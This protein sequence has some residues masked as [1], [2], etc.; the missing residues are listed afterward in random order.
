[1]FDGL[2]TLEEVRAWIQVPV[3]ALSDEQ[4]QQVID[5]ELA[6]QMS[7]IVVP[8]TPEPPDPPVPYPPEL[9]QA[10]FRRVA[11]QVALR[12]LPLGIISDVESAP[13]QAAAWDS[14][15]ARLEQPW[16]RMVLG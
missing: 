2:P 1:M 15:V 13:I 16:Q 10:L 4:L 8:D 14:E 9:E 6:L 3:S 5:A 11:H 12:G 7:G